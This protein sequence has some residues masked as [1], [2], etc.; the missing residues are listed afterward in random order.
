MNNH[1]PS[2]PT[3]LNLSLIFKEL[4]IKIPV[5]KKSHIF[6]LTEKI[7]LDSCFLRIN[8]V[9][10]LLELNCSNLTVDYDHFIFHGN[11]QII[12]SKNFYFDSDIFQRM[13]NS[14]NINKAHRIHMKSTYNLNES[15]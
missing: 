6:N 12:Y 11:K 15:R 13:F 3:I 10:L 14:A 4:V 5:H 2:Y 7:F 9:Y 8:L 1:Y